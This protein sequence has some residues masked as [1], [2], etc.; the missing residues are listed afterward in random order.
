M[1]KVFI[2]IKPFFHFRYVVIKQESRQ[3][4][5]SFHAAQGFLWPKRY[6]IQ[7]FQYVQF[8]W[9]NQSKFWSKNLPLKANKK[10]TSDQP[11]TKSC[12]N[13]IETLA[14]M[15]FLRSPP[16]CPPPKKP[17]VDRLPL[18]LLLVVRW[19]NSCQRDTS[20]IIT[21]DRRITRA[22]SWSAQD[23]G[24][25]WVPCIYVECIST[26][27]SLKLCRRTVVRQRNSSYIIWF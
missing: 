4:G 3:F 13:C 10:R 16:L 15:T 12:G 14:V 21:K 2:R 6:R 17:S 5:M 8:P 18:L 7:R 1:A 19:R 23:F 20:Y 22:K 26:A 24:F 11:Q 25:R 27:I 9:Q